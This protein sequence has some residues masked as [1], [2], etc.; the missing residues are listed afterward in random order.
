[1][2]KLPCILYN[3]RFSPWNVENIE[4]YKECYPTTRENHYWHLQLFFPCLGNCCHTTQTG[5]Y[6]IKH[7]NHIS[8]VWNIQMRMLDCWALGMWSDRQSL[9]AR[10]LRMDPRM[11]SAQ[12]THSPQSLTQVSS[13]SLNSRA[14]IILPDP[15]EA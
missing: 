14:E 8:L 10:V 1:M 12:F 13:G 9:Q 4:N 6:A 5:V 2:I 7:Y 15:W 3:I 11:T